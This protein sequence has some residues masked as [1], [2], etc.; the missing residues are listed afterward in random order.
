MGIL[1]NLR[2][3]RTANSSEQE[4][5]P[6]SE[7]GSS[8]NSSTSKKKFSNLMPFVVALVVIAEIGFLGRLDMAKN[9]AMFDSLADIFYKPPLSS[10]ME[11]TGGGADGLVLTEIIGGQDSYSDS[12]EEWL[13]R[14]DSVVYSRDFEKDPIL[15]VGAEQVC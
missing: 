15:V 1:S 8:S 11:E 7:N 2:G 12:C 6:I 3:G 14:E 9:A 10:E 4:V 5:L 13:E